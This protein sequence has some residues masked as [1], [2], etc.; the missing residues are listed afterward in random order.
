MAKHELRR[1]AKGR[2]CTIRIP[3]VCNWNPET[4]VL[5]H[6]SGAGMAMKS[7]DRHAAIGCS[8]CHDEID[9]RT[10]LVSSDFAHTCKLEAV[11]RTQEIWIK[12][13]LM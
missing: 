4:T 3:G 5:C 1:Q 6:L 10:R 2:D 11:I 13:G 12:E 9:R 7:D 8:A